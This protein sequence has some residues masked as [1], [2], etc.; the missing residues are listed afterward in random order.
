MCVAHVSNR[1]L[2][3]IRTTYDRVSD[4]IEGQLAALPLRAPTFAWSSENG[5]GFLIVRGAPGEGIPVLPP[6]ARLEITLTMQGGEGIALERI[7]LTGCTDCGP[8]VIQGPIADM[9][10]VILQAVRP[11]L[12][13]ELMVL[14]HD[15]GRALRDQVEA[16]DEPG[17]TSR[18]LFEFCEG[19]LAVTA[20][21]GDLD[22]GTMRVNL[23]YTT[24]GNQVI[25]A[26]VESTRILGSRAVGNLVFV[27]RND[28]NT[29]EWCEFIVERRH[30]ER[31]DATGHMAPGATRE[32]TVPLQHVLGNDLKIPLW[33]PGIAGL[34]GIAADVQFQAPSIGDGRVE[35]TRFHHP[36]PPPPPGRRESPH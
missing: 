27:F 5:R 23:P 24:S 31:V 7:K 8:G 12:D 29:G 34:A 4:R 6:E 32:L 17:Q 35:I 1:Q 15:L 3:S 19:H 20:Y 10:E 18:Q 14:S 25:V 11:G 21:T 9:I 36:P 33:T 13:H 28:T 16:M 22:P 30:G 26:R 2:V